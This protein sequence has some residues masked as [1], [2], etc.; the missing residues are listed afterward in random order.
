MNTKDYYERIR[1]ALMSPR[2]KNILV[3]LAF[4]CISSVLWVVMTLNEDV[5]K[6]MRCKIEIINCPDSVT[7]IS[8]LPEAIN[9][10]VNARASQLLKYEWGDGPIVKIDYKYFIHGNTIS[11]GDAELRSAM[12]NLFGSGSQITAVN[13]DSITLLFTSRPP[14][15]M[16]VVVDS[17]ITTSPNVIMV[18]PPR[19]L[20]DSVNVY[21]LNELPANLK[22]V[23][24]APV[25]VENL[26]SSKV[27]KVKL[28]T[29]YNTRAIP[30][31]VEVELSVEKLINTHTTMQIKPI[32]VPAGE[33]LLLFPNQVDVGYMVPLTDFESKK[34]GFRILVDYRWLREH[35]GAK[36][37]PIVIDNTSGRARGIQL[38][39]DSV[40]YIIER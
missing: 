2:G 19:A 16:S 22:S 28:I 6:D 13:P 18:A 12:R 20:V 8:Y 37:F 30:D 38:P 25:E 36:S 1:K 7:M 32:N 31:S 4:L 27:V 14:K 21:S 15:R 5:Q 9:V 40:S 26:S 23:S 11:L 34:T 3:F 17:H 39:V 29:P 35:P 33:K 24:T 10:N